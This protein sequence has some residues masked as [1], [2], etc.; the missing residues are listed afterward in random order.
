[1]RA[2]SCASKGLTTPPWATP[3]R[4]HGAEGRSKALFA[5]HCGRGH[6]AGEE[7]ADDPRPGAATRAGEVEALDVGARRGAVPEEL[8]RG[9]RNSVGGAA[10]RGREALVG[11]RRRHFVVGNLVTEGG[12][13]A[14]RGCEKRGG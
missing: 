12:K 8:G 9:H 6:Y 11:E 13:D 1:M 4:E 7:G 3:R 10:G 14:A 5:A 2:T